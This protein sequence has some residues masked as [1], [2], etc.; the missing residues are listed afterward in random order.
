M[1]TITIH[2]RVLR[3]W[4]WVVFGLTLVLIY[5]LLKAWQ[6]LIE[7]STAFS[8]LALFKEIPQAALRRA[9][10]FSFAMAVSASLCIVFLAE[11]FKRYIECCFPKDP[12]KYI[13][14]V[15][16]HVPAQI[17]WAVMTALGF[18]FYLKAI[19]RDNGTF[20]HL[21][22]SAIFDLSTKT[23]ARIPDAHQ[24]HTI[25][26]VQ[27]IEGILN[28]LLIAMAMAWG[29]LGHTLLRRAVKPDV[30]HRQTA[31][32][33]GYLALIRACLA[34]VTVF[35][36]VVAVNVL[37]KKSQFVPDF[38]EGVKNVSLAV[39]TAVLLWACFILLLVRAWI[40]GHEVIELSLWPF[41]VRERTARKT[42]PA[43]LEKRQEPR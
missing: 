43:K 10:D 5:W 24:L 1:L 4:T 7:N 32:S 29:V 40:K 37:L 9:N 26:F 38:F 17:W 20:F 33:E 28:L 11:A 2:P 21:W 34:P 39:A 16:V 8:I 18:F 14:A 6:I 19:Y 15:G 13:A 12:Q 3:Y 42:P 41:V 27:T 23:D 35:G 36:A 30:S 31:V 22:A 25:A